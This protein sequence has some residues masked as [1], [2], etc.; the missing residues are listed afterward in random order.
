MRDGDS[1]YRF[2]FPELNVRGE[3]VHLDA[4]WR[5]V[6]ERHEYPAPVRRLL[7][8]AMAAA[9]LLTATIK[10][11]GSLTL[12]IQGEG[13]LHL[14]VVQCTSQRTLRGLA[15]WKDAVPDGSLQEMVG[16]GRLVL[17]I[18]PGL[19]R[20]RYQGVVELSQATLSQALEEYFSRSEQLP[21]RLW[22]TANASRAAGL[23]LQNLPG[24][25]ADEDGWSRVE[26][27]GATITDGE[28]LEL[29]ASDLIRRLFHEEDV[30]LFDPEPVSFRCG[31]S[32]ER[33]EAVLRGLGHA[34]VQ[35]ILREEGKIV[36]DCEFC[37]QHYEF[38]VVDAEQIFAGGVSPGVPQTRH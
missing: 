31:C 21:T 5:A 38:D 12:Q 26:H 15:R 25:A 22:L 37:N 33:I 19:G 14:L 7:G 20:E 35:D 3:V 17:T 23:L 9:A 27:L 24:E 2:L 1:L 8:E 34:E 18:D 32:R 29:Q 6:L 30:Q 28:L 13:P 4:T 10:L 16:D 36:V 11:D